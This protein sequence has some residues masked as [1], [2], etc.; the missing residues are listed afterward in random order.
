VQGVL[1]LLVGLYVLSRES[2][3]AR[4]LI[5]RLRASHPHLGAKLQVWRRQYRPQSQ[6]AEPEPDDDG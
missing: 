1:L 3:S 2:T 6:V 5:Y 4:R